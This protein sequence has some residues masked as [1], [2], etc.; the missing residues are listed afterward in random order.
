MKILCFGSLN[1][2][3]I[4]TLDHIVNPGET[5]HS[6]SLSTI[7]GGKGLN[8]SIA[9]ARA[10]ADVYHAGNVGLKDG[11]IMLEKLQSVGVDTR[12]V[13]QKE[14]PSGQALIQVDKSGQ[15]SIILLGG[16]NQTVNKAQ[17]DETLAFFEAGDV[18][19]LQNEI[20]HLETI[21]QKAHE[22]GLIIAF[23]PSP[24][25]KRLSEL[26]LEWMDYLFLNEIEAAALLEG[27]GFVHMSELSQ[28][29]SQTLFVLTLGGDGVDVLSHG[30][31]VHCEAH[32]VT[33]KDTTA[34]GDTFTGYFLAEHL[35][36]ASTAE[37][38]K[39]ATKAA[40]LCIGKHGASDSIP[41]KEQV[42]AAIF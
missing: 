2:D 17:I 19:V 27:T 3:Y 28:R 22:K 13:Q 6:E 34:A 30:E 12:F 35:A 8:Q 32:R 31:T 4:Y 37:S 21:I 38:A 25:E 29:F 42:K 5:E 33:P 20:N 39:V 36:G 14:G 24:Y 15:N 40:A 23:N 9:L 11:G 10:G 18:I 16:D 7:C 26:P 1:I 41:T